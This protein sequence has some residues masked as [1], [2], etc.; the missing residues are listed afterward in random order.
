MGCYYIIGHCIR[1]SVSDLVKIKGVKVQIIHWRHKETETILDGS[2]VGQR[3]QRPLVWFF[4]THSHTVVDLKT[5]SQALVEQGNKTLVL[6]V[7]DDRGL[8]VPARQSHIFQSFFTKL[9]N[10]HFP[11]TLLFLR[12]LA[13]WPCW[14]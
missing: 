4:V 13:I 10:T 6:C 7:G 2:L 12:V 11:A 9:Q 3:N 8:M 5:Q 14:A 1:K